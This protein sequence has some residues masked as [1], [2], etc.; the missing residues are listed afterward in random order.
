MGTKRDYYEILGIEKNADAGKCV[1]NY[2]NKYMPH[3]AFSVQRET[4]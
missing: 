4:E 3:L 2:Y 1:K